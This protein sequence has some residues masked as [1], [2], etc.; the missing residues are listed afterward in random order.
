[1]GFTAGMDD[2]DGERFSRAALSSAPPARRVRTPVPGREAA[3]RGHVAGSREE[4]PLGSSTGVHA[5]RVRGLDAAERR[6]LQQEAQLLAALEVAGVGAAPTVLELEDD[7]YVRETGPELGRR[8]GR[9]VAEAVTPPTGERHAMSHAR[10]A[11]DELIDALHARGWVLGAPHGGGVGARADGSV[12]VLALSG[13]RREESLSARQADRRWVDSVLGDQ[14]RTLRRRVHVARSRTVSDR[15]RPV[16][17]RPTKTAG[18]ARGTPVDENPA[19]RHEGRTAPARARGTVLS[20]LRDVLAQRRLRRIA[21]LSGALVLLV[22]GVAALGAGWVHVPARPGTEGEPP[23]TAAGSTPPGSVPAPDI[24]QPQVLVAEL[25][26]ARHAYVTG[27]TDRPAS[28]PGSVAREDDERVRD[29]YDGI[30]VGAGGPVV[31]SAEL[32]EQSESEG[33]AVLHAVTSMEELH[34]EEADGTTTAVPATAP[35]TVRLV[36]EWNGEEW[37]ITAVAQLS[38]EGAPQEGP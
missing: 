29:A 6:R 23:V 11:L 25:A 21:V 16:A 15:L 38:A 5:V 37:L 12:L 34:L 33:T 9:H 2:V 22:G 20:S 14:D 4:Q 7:G 31:H 13:L 24:E 1:M 8:S 17:E 36:L 28:A 35:V 26:G 19:A 18:G 30:S 10:E 3:G 32:V 27:L